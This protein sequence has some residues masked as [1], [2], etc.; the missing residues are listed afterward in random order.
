MSRFILAI[1]IGAVAIAVMRSSSSSEQ[2]E[3]LGELEGINDPH[4]LKAILLAGGPGSGKSFISEMMF[5]G[6]GLKFLNSDAAFEFLLHKRNL[7][8]TID[9]DNRKQAAARSSAKALTKLQRVNWTNGMLGLVI[10]GTG[11][12]F[13]S[14]NATKKALERIGYTTHMVYVDTSLEV[15]LERNRSRPRTVPDEIVTDGWKNVNRNMSR[16]RRL[17]GDTFSV[18]TN[19]DDLD[20]KG[21]ER[22]ALK[23]NREA[24]RILRRPLTNKRGLKII[25]ALLA[26]GGKTL[27]DL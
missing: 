6:H 5:A 7:P 24:G 2:L 17:F 21:L 3:G 23:L 9:I 26:T 1:G 15:A 27:R 4:I 8:M 14:I 20:A 12:D 16:Y 11:K 25:T 19:N 18:V 22:L 13:D 10:D